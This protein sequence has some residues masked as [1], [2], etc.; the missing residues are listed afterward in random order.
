M[1]LAVN[2]PPH[3][4]APGHARRSTSSS[5]AASIR[6]A[7][8]SPT[9]SNTLTTVRSRPAWRP[10]LIVPPYTNTAGIFIRAMAIMAPGMFLSHPPTTSTP[11]MLCALHAVSIESAITSRE[12]REYFIPSV[13]MEMPSLTVIVPNDWGM[14]PAARRAASARLA[15]RS[16]PTLQGVMVE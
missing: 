1:V 15:S 6:P 12:T 11:S 16:N 7:E 13:P 8:Y 2:M 14:T 10:G 9:A 5:S 3:E 4:P